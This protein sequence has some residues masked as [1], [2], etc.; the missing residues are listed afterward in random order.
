MKSDFQKTHAIIK[1]V[2]VIFLLSPLQLPDDVR[3]SLTVKSLVCQIRC[4]TL[5]V[6]NLDGGFIADE[7]F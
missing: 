4:V 2:L 6:F 5:K 3:L 1:G 7:H